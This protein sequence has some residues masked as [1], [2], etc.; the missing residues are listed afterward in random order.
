MLVINPWTSASMAERDV[1]LQ[2]VYW[3]GG[4]LDAGFGFED[5]HWNCET[6][7]RKFKHIVV[8]KTVHYVRLKSSGSLNSSNIEKAVIVP[9]SSLFDH[10]P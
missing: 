7:A 9:A 5:W 4:G 8:P 6:L 10:K 2:C 3:E 1:Y